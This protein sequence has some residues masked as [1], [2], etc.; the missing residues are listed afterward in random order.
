MVESIVEDAFDGNADP[1]G[2]TTTETQPTESAEPT[3]TPQDQQPPAVEGKPTGL[4]G[5]PFK[6]VAGLVKSYKEIQ[7]VVAS[8]DKQ[9][10]ELTAYVQDLMQKGQPP[11]QEDPNE[12]WTKFANDPIGFL[13][14]LFEAQI[15]ERISGAVNPLQNDIQAY[16]AEAEIAGFLKSHPEFTEADEAEVVNILQEKPHLMQMPDR[17]ERAYDALIARRFRESQ[18]KQ[19]NA[20]AVRDAKAA[21]G[22]GSKKS[23]LAVKKGGDEFDD[24]LTSDRDM[25]E[26]YRMGRKD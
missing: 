21:A 6:D 26:L 15:Q 1:L 4:E 19:G 23:A 14:S 8:R 7:R 11:K 18:Q 3:Q 2:E 17:F 13:K 10:K 12:F 20:N 5:T 22:I 24:V 9:L 25:R 16:K